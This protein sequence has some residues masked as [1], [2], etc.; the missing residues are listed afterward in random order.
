[1]MDWIRQW[2]L[3]VA[4]TALL[5]TLAEGFVA[6]EALRRLTRLVGGVL[7]ALALL[8]PLGNLPGEEMDLSLAEYR[9]EMEELT[10]Q[11]HREWDMTYSAIIEEELAAYIVDKA[12]DMG[13][14]TKAQV[15]VSVDE[16]GILLPVEAQLTIP[17]EPILSGWLDE[18]LGIPTQAQYWQEE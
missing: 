17:E 8:R 18:E 3:G 1:M 2:L 14:E 4:A 15:R 9:R 13:L 16:R 7:L 6:Q 10:E 12:A 5:V 11:Y